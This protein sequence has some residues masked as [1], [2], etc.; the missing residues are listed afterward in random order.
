MKKRGYQEMRDI[1]HSF[2]VSLLP[3]SLISILK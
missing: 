1:L 3:I 2:Y